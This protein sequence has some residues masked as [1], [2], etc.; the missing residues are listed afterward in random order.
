MIDIPSD[1]GICYHLENMM[2]VEIT[3]LDSKSLYEAVRVMVEPVTVE[4]WEMLE[5]N[6]GL[7]E[8]QLMNQVATVKEHQIIPVWVNSSTV[9]RMI[10]KETIPSGICKLVDGTE[11]IVAPKPRTAPNGT[12]LSNQNEENRATHRPKKAI[13]RVQH[14]FAGNASTHLI[15][16]RAT[17]D[18]HYWTD[19]ML[20]CVSSIANTLP[21]LARMNHSVCPTNSSNVLPKPPTNSNSTKLFLRV[22]GSASVHA[23]HALV[24]VNT[25][26]QLSL[27]QFSRLLAKPQPNIAKPQQLQRL[28]LKPIRWPSNAPQKL[29]IPILS[30]ITEQVNKWMANN[31]GRAMRNQGR[32]SQ[33][34][35]SVPLTNGTLVALDG[36]HYAA[37]CN[38]VPM[39]AHLEANESRQNHFDETR[40]V[41]AEMSTD[42]N[43]DGVRSSGNLQTI[44]SMVPNLPGMTVLQ[45]IDQVREAGARVVEA[46]TEG[47]MRASRET[48]QLAAQQELVT[49][50]FMIDSDAVFSSD[51]I[52]IGPAI[53]SAWLFPL[54]YFLPS[55][56]STAAIQAPAVVPTKINSHSRTSST[57]AIS[58]T[59]GVVDLTQST[60]KQPYKF[61]PSPFNGISAPKSTQ[62]LFTAGDIGGFDTEMATATEIIMNCVGR[63]LLK[64]QLRWK[65]G[66][67]VLVTG[68][69][70][71]GKSMLLRALGSQFSKFPEI[72]A[73]PFY[74]GCSE[75]S[76]MKVGKIVEAL[77]QVFHDAIFCQPA[78]VLLDDLDLVSP[79][80]NSESP[81]AAA[82][83]AHYA[84]ILAIII[85]F[86][87]SIIEKGHEIV[88]VAT[89]QSN[90]A[91]H[92]DLLHPY[93]LLKHIPLPAPNLKSRVSIL[94]KI[95]T[96]K[97]LI[98]CTDHGE[99]LD[100]QS[101][102]GSMELSRVAICMD[103]YLGGDIEQ[104]I[105]RAVHAA[106]V[107]LIEAQSLARAT[108]T[109]S[110]HEKSSQST[111]LAPMTGSSA[112]TGALLTSPS[113]DAASEDT[114]SEFTSELAES[115]E[116]WNMD[117]HTLFSYQNGHQ[118]PNMKS[119][120][121]PA[122]SIPL[123]L[124]VQ[125]GF[126]PI[127]LRGASLNLSSNT[128]WEDVG[129][130]E[131]LKAE[132][133]ETIEWPTKYG[134]LFKNS[135]IRARSGI[136]L[137]GPS[138]CGKT[139]VANAI[140]KECGLNFIS[141]KGPELL[142][143]Y[144][145]QSEQSV[146]DVFARAQS[147]SPCVLF[148]DEFDAIAPRRGHDNTGVTD[149][150]VNQFLT[151]LDG[152]EGLTGVYVLAASSRPELIDP[153]LLRPG[154]LDKSYYIGYPDVNDREL[155][156][157]ALGRKM[158]FAPDVDFS[159]IAS[160]AEHCTGADLQALCYNS[161]L[162]A[163]HE[164][165]EE[166][167]Q[168]KLLQTN[169]S[170]IGN[171]NHQDSQYASLRSASD[172][173]IVL[174]Y[175]DLRQQQQSS[176]ADPS[177][178]STSTAMSA[179]VK[180]QIMK[181]LETIQSSL[182]E[183]SAAL[184]GAD[185]NGALG[186]NDASSGVIISMKHM[187]KAF[188]GL[189]PSSSPSERKRNEQTYA[190]FLASRG[191]D[192]A[193]VA[194]AIANQKATLA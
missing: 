19:G 119:G 78:V 132:L 38:I 96:R 10:V 67:I 60:N 128:S 111:H 69:H 27:H 45:Q 178:P 133:R 135:P 140:A 164:Q 149:R 154:R 148:F 189:T 179:A 155:I 118:Q 162:E 191:T 7:V 102:S 62:I 58:V 115:S 57:S 174:K 15:C 147:A 187:K 84:Q 134:F 150:V 166:A 49:D 175:S 75:F 44:S 32:T 160:W 145:G 124:E 30:Q 83:K 35:Y 152:V 76:G 188:A 73:C 80:E 36:Q 91:I 71:C 4:D 40:A 122:I 169:S 66:G 165:L 81:Q 108:G 127:S 193:D 26:S 180:D 138:G 2:E 3:I 182:Y 177:L 21:F 12:S 97:A 42:M 47:K 6:A 14:Y 163:I 33:R 63:R 56:P 117:Y 1:V 25:A 41:L 48:A 192:F 89:A 130:L 53:D 90:S 43:S 113:M 126:V 181:R 22:F 194:S 139:L 70:G 184:S 157:R 159:A 61:P 170:P 143:K 123:I 185:Q 171:S 88:I 94:Q 64:Q 65:A 99:I 173:M 131:V 168:R 51:S 20:I 129:G 114:S 28:L 37:Y 100:E 104:L 120:A 116:L 146:R 183:E 52:E 86:I 72:L 105:D 136:L 82:A 11:V 121:R 98:L 9:V 24:H 13:L 16:D 87:E 153:A 176:H 85:K 39:R 55:K 74:V 23:N 18:H 29:D 110:I 142:N 151:E 92:A 125:E 79:A 59:S 17:M 190:S 77:Q 54:D 5:M 158:S 31:A 34:S 93:Y 186:T 156:L 101:A 167:K 112:P 106:S 109:N 8:A 50:L 95:I 161:Q 103:G 141:V 68:Q 107:R 172:Q 137:F 46:K 144:I